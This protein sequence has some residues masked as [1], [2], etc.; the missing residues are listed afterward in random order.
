M[1]RLEDNLALW[2]IVSTCLR[3]ELYHSYE[4]ATSV[5]MLTPNVDFKLAIKVSGLRRP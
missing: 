5:E 1:E 4:Y 3:L 2:T